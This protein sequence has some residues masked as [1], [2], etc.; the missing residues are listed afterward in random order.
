MD[1]LNPKE[2]FNLSMNLIIGALKLQDKALVES[3]EK[4]LTELLGS[5]C[6]SDIITA[7][8][9]QLAQTDPNTFDWAW[10]NLY[11]L[12]ACQHLIEGIVMFAV[13]K[14]INQGFILGQDFSLSPT[15]KIWLCQEA[16]AALLEKSSATDCIFLKEILQVPPDI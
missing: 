3:C 10:R 1:N 16:K 9:F 4:T 5:K 8:V 12:D 2:E 14:L 11:S 6:T 13:K 7:V 15:G